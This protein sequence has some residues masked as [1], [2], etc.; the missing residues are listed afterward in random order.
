MY[1]KSRS[2]DPM[3]VISDNTKLR[4]ILNYKKMLSINSIINSAILW[5]K[6]ILKKNY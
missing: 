2:G 4:K 1:Y 6:F 3:C 5:E